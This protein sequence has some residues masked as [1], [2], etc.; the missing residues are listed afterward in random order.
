MNIAIKFLPLVFFVMLMAM[1]LSCSNQYKIK[2]HV[3][4][5]HSHLALAKALGYEAKADTVVV[6]RTIVNKGAEVDSTLFWNI[7]EP[8]PER[9]KELIRDTI[10]ITK[11]RVR[12]KLKIDTARVYIYVK[13]PDDSLEVESTTIINPQEV[14]INDRGIPKNIWIVLVNFA[15]LLILFSI[16]MYFKF[17]KDDN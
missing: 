15:A 13:C 5:A 17:K 7:D 12:V 9:I 1:L 6:Y 11:D 2:K 4:K 10:Y 14:S 3:R 8:V 16:V